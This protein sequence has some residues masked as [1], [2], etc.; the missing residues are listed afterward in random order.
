MSNYRWNYLFGFLSSGPVKVAPEPI[1]SLIC[2]TAD[3]YDHKTG[4]ALLAP[5]G[6]RRIQSALESEFE[7]DGVAVQHP[8]MIERAI[9][10]ETKVVGLSEMSPLGLG[11][12]DTAMS[13]YNTTWNRKWFTDLTQ[14]LKVLKKRFDFKVVVGGAG[15]WQLLERG[16]GFSM[17]NA[18]LDPKK[19]EAY[20]V[21][22]VVLGE[23]DKIAPQLFQ[24]IMDGRAPEVIR[25]LTNT[26]MEIS[27][28]PE[29]REPTLTGLVECMRG[30]GRGCDFCAPNLRMKRDFPPERVAEETSVNIRWGYRAVWLQTEELTLYGCTSRDKWPNEDAIVELYQALL[31]AGAS[32][33]GATHWTFAGVRAA[34]NLIGK[35]SAMNRLGPGRWMGVQPGLEY[36]SPRLVKK[37]MPYKA[38]PFTPEEYPET[39]REAIRIMNRYYYYPACTL[40]IGHPGEEP[41]EVQMTIELV[42]SLSE[43]DRVH[44]LFAPLLYVDYFRPDQ[45]MTFDKMHE[46]YWQLYYVCWK[47][48]VREFQEK[49][50]MATQSFGFIQRAVTVMGVYALARYILKF[51]VDQFRRRFGF[52]PHWAN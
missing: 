33:I 8:L 9:G 50:W 23:C 4:R 38:K 37:F 13:W 6:L 47:H 5:L 31:R 30:C 20:G 42:R 29:I 17:F 39:V 2:P 7:F 12:V 27:D 11:P 32:A 26:I 15:A 1:Y 19:K 46:K 40:I 35:L 49:I 25:V 10:P 48:N 41:D 36:A 3:T 51:I 34:P 22:H 18:K 43:K 44:A 45:T 14:R 21:D 24:D 28:I 52:T 16:P